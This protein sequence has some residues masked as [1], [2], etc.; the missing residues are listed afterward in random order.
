VDDAG[1]PVPEIYCYAPQDALGREYD[2]QFIP[3][4]ALA[5]MT[6]IDETIAR[7]MSPALARCLDEIN[8]EAKDEKEEAQ[9]T[10][11]DILADQ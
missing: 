3:V 2:T 6:E 9:V 8:R 10:S 4:E 7:A 5:A 1:Q 11:H